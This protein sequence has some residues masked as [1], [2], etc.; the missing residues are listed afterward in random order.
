VKYKIDLYRQGFPAPP[1]IMFGVY[2]EM[3]GRWEVIDTFYTRESAEAYMKKICDLPKQ[4]EVNE[5]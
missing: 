4:W 2:R 3:N 5:P 1:G